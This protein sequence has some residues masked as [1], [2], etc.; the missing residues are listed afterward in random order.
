MRNKEDMQMEIFVFCKIWN[1]I[2]IKDT[3]EE[4]DTLREMNAVS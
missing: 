1:K 2:R 4:C 3:G